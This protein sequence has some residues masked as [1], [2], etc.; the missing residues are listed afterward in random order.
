MNPCPNLETLRRLVEGTPNGAGDP[1]LEAHLEICPSCQDRLAWWRADDSWLGKSDAG[2]PD[3]AEEPSQVPPDFLRRLVATN[4]LLLHGSGHT[5]EDS[6]DGNEVHFPGAP[7]A[8]GPLGQLGSFHIIEELGRGNFGFVFRAWDERLG[9]EVAIKILKPEPA[10]GDTNR[11]RLV[12]EAQ[13]AA[14]ITSDH[15]VTVHDAGSLP[16]YPSPYL[17]MEY[18]AGE[19]LAALLAPR[20][21]FAPAEAADIC[22]QVALG[23]SAAHARGLVHRDVKPSNIIITS[24][25][26]ERSERR[27]RAKITD[28]GLARALQLTGD[29]NIHSGQLIGTPAYMGP[30]QIAAPGQVDGRG[31]VFSLG[32]VLYE[33]L[34]GER[35]FRGATPH[36]IL[37]HV[38]HEEPSPPRKLNPGV[39]RD[40]ETICLKCLAKEPHHRYASAAALAEDLGR[41]LAGEP[42]RARPLGRLGRTL[43]WAR[44]R[45][46]LAALGVVLFAAVV[47]AGWAAVAEVRLTEERVQ[48][49]EE[50]TRRTLAEAAKRAAEERQ[51]ALKYASLVYASLVREIE[52]DGARPYLGCTWAD[53]QNLAQA[54]RLETEARKPVELRNAAATL[55]RLDLR[56][57][58][59]WKMPGT[60][61]LI[62]FKVGLDV[63]RIIPWM[64]EPFTVQVDCLAFNPARHLLAMAQQRGTVLCAVRLVDL[65]RQCKVADFAYPASTG[66]GALAFSPDGQWLALGTAQGDIHVWDTTQPKPEPA[67]S[68]RGHRDNVTGLAFAPSST[69]LVSCSEDQ[70]LKSWAVPSHGHSP[71]PSQWDKLSASQYDWRF[72]GLAMSP[73]GG[74]L[75]CCTSQGLKVFQGECLT[76]REPHPADF[77]TFSGGNDAVCFSPDGRILAST[78]NRRLVLID[79]AR[80]KVIRSF[81]SPDLGEVAAHEK[82]I[83][84]LDF[85]PDGSLLVSSSW[86]RKVKIWEVA[87]GRLLAATPAALTNTEIPYAVFVLGAQGPA[88]ATTD[89]NRAVL[90][91]LSNR[92]EQTFLAQQTGPLV[93]IDFSPDSHSLVCLAEELDDTR[94]AQVGA[95]TV[96]LLGTPHGPAPLLAAAALL[97]GSAPTYTS[98]LT[99]WEVETGRLQDRWTATHFLTDRAQGRPAVAYHPKGDLLAYSSTAGGLHLWDLRARKLVRSVPANVEGALSFAE[100]GEILAAGV[101][102]AKGQPQGSAMVLFRV[103]DLVALRPWKND[104]SQRD[105]GWSGFVSVSAGRTWV[106]AGSHDGTT[107][108]FR[109]IGDEEPVTWPNPGGPV[110]SVALS[111]DETLAASGSQGGQLQLL[112]VSDGRSVAN[113]VPFRNSV[114]SVAFSRSGDLFA[115]ASL[116]QTIRLW[117]RSGDTLDELM[118]LPSPSGGVSDIRL[119]PDGTK[120]AVLVKKETAVRIWHL[121]RLRTRLEAI[122]LGW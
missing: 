43:K 79:T 34:T 80:L 42:I 113:L 41:F 65:R 84:H 36:A 29:G 88:L 87:S 28:F 115:A 31:D 46:S 121:D 14:G 1:A 77:L 78:R 90:H 122:G 69:R 35:P 111:P 63:K 8:K 93:A 54:G 59:A 81:W 120:L 15:V 68:W 86:D 73:D 104:R 30:E 11:A 98:T 58:T 85:S 60:P 21:P 61:E 95:S 55:V 51:T 71:R 38:L 82:D 3:P 99:T 107:K 110:T 32:V 75:A 53:W 108:L 74:L 17:V 64:P 94:L 23:L 70:T 25:A 117:R 16:D 97:P 12:K 10:A 83:T 33:M 6:D 49:T 52:K 103:P 22:R 114:T 72:K 18:I 116:D 45:P 19:S 105:K 24:A 119:S 67:F 7:T 62:R 89:G 13:A 26:S 50:A 40:L 27:R 44:R 112:R 106:A 37:A 57:D 102:P 2:Y 39:P 66:A 100:D 9:R 4:P 118:T 109:L 48:R 76:L 56:P 20:Q 92:D 101:A 47:A 5:A 96:G 91:E